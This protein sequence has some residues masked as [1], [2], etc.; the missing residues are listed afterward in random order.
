VRRLRTWALASTLA[1]YLLIFVGGLVRVSGAGLGC[2][3]WPKCFG[4]WVPPTGVSQIPPEIDPASFNMTLAW[5]EYINRLVGVAIGLLILLTA[6]LAIK[7]ARRLPRIL[8][9]ALGAL[10]LVMVEGWQGSQ[11]IGTRLAPFIVTIHMVLAFLIVTL[12]LFTTLQA[13]H[14]QANGRRVPSAAPRSIKWSLVSVWGLSIVA[15][16]LGTQVRSGIETQIE[17]FPLTERTLLLSQVGWVYFLHLLLG[18]AI[19]VATLYIGIRILGNRDW[20]S[21]LVL[22]STWM[23]II[24]SVAQVGV[25]IGLAAVGLPALLQVFHLWL[26]SLYVGALLVLHFALGQDRRFAHAA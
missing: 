9:P 17:Q 20:P 18:S 7:H 12:L 14:V 26:S 5:I 13:F 16:A 21:P 6:I 4:R 8:Y 15:I 22:P 11:V 1:T 25:G 3:D 23:L 19:V 2:P 10:V 24:L